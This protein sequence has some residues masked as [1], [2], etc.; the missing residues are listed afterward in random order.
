[1]R[2][3]LNPFIQLDDYR[4]FGCSPDNPCGLCMEFYED[5]DQVV[6]RWDPKDHFQGYN[7]VLHGGIQSTL[8]DEIASWVVFIKLRTAGVTSRLEIQFKKPVYTNK[9]SLT[10]RAG[11][12]TI[13]DRLT[14]VSVHLLDSDNTI[15]AEA[16]VDYF[17][18]PANLAERRLRY[19]GYEK[20]FEKTDS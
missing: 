20:F 2:K 12:K 6:C 9:G 14:T 3:I 10:L 19:P 16:L 1:L 13:Q 7:N 15:C 5:G 8:A 18:Y 17:I 11:I 4:C